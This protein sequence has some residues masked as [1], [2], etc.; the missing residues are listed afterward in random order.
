M[1]GREIRK[2]LKHVPNF[3][4][5][6][7]RDTLPKWIGTNVG[8]IV[9]TDPIGK[10]GQHWV[11]I[12][13][14]KDGYCEYFDHYGIPPL[15]NEFMDFLTTN[16][17]IGVRWSHQQLQC[18]DCVTCGFYCV[19]Y[20]KFRCNGFTLSDLL[21]SF[22]LDPYINDVIVKNRIKNPIF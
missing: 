15:Y 12:Y 16:S 14:D 17:T 2:I 20:I 8:L 22:T 19:E 21:H 10:R 6:Y 18:V 5:V 1:D 7:A 3:K 13:R 11:A 4:D 9:N